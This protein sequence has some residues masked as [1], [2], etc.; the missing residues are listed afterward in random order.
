MCSECGCVASM[1]LH[2]IGQHRLAGGIKVASLF[3]AS[4]KIG[5][6]MCW[7]RSTLGDFPSL[8]KLLLRKST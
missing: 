6:A 8:Q 3:D 4:K 5:A 1:G 7:K 2:A